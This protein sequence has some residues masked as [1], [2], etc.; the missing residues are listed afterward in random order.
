VIGDAAERAAGNGAPSGPRLKASRVAERL[1]RRHLCWRGCSMQTAARPAGLVQRRA[2]RLSPRQRRLRPSRA[3]NVR[4]GT[5]WP[6]CRL[7]TAALQEPKSAVQLQYKFTAP[8]L[9]PVSRVKQR[10]CSTLW[11]ATNLAR[12]ARNDAAL[13]R[14]TPAARPRTASWLLA[15][16]SCCHPRASDLARTTVGAAAA[17]R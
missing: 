8:K 16:A 15:I 1:Q 4:L 9:R 7:P 14:R 11:G 12:G 5:W 6:L 3:E 2:A 10:R 13:A 17:R